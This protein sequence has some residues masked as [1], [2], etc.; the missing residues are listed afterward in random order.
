M[1]A[2]IGMGLV[3][4]A[5]GRDHFRLE[6]KAELQA[7]LFYPAGQII[8][9]LRQLIGVHNPVSQR[10]GIVIPL[11]EPAVVQHHQLNAQLL[12]GFGDGDNLVGIEIEV[13]GFPVVNQHR[14]G[15]I[16]VQPSDQ[17]GAV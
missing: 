13:G 5:Y 11:A 7:K 6:P 1:Q 4:L 3:Q 2:P 8:Q 14:A 9:P 10:G 15:L 16:T 17:A 12:G